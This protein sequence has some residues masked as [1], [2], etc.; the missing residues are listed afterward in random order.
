MNVYVTRR[1][2]VFI[3]LLLSFSSA[4]AQ[5]SS[6]DP[7]S[8]VLYFSLIP[9]KNIDQQIRELAP[10]IDLLEKQL[11]KSIKIIRPQS[12]NAVMEGILSKTID[13]AI[14]GPASYAK[15][16]ARDSRIEAFASFSRKKGFITPEGSYYYSVLFTLKKNRFKSIEDLKQKKIALTDP[17]STSGSVIPNMAFSK[18]LGT[19]LKD[20]FETIVYTGSHDRS[21]QSVLRGH[22]D[23]AFV[24]SSRIDEAVEKKVLAPEQVEILWQSQPIHHDPFVF[25]SKVD[26]SLKNQ[27]KKVMLSSQPCLNAMLENMHM[28]GIVAVSD[29]NYQA[30]H[31]IV[32]IQN[33]Q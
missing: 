1:L 29:E 12:Y 3:C 24:S 2:I 31:E 27:I 16:R 10:L 28:A 5:P 19:S 26:N 11:Q 21:I 7:S 33:R 30:I 13:F 15:A 32:S 22:V 25:S 18:H 20:F 8:D 9:K 4:F 23:A 14:L 6:A 17:E